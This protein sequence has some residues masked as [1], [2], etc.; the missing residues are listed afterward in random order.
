MIKKK[1]S[2]KTIKCSFADVSSVFN[3]AIDNNE[4]V[5][6]PCKKV[7]TPKIPNTEPEPF[8]LDEITQILN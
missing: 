8:T 6:N 4:I 1:L 3:L 7:K 5:K 2:P